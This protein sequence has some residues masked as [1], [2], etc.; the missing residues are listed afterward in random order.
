[1]MTQSGGA[2]EYTDCISVGFSGCDTKPSDGEVPV[3]LE[4]SGP[5]CPRVVG[6]DRVLSMDR[7]K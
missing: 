6:A 7:I 1:M 3:V 4:F 2:V 5:L